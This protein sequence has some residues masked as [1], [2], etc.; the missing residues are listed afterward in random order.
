MYIG[1]HISIW[2]DRRNN[3]RLLSLLMSPACHCKGWDGLAGKAAGLY[4]TSPLFSVEKCNICVN[5]DMFITQW[6]H[7]CFNIS[8]IPTDI[9]SDR[10]SNLHTKQHAT[11]HQNMHTHDDVIK[12]KHFPRYWPFLRWIHRSPVNSQHKG[13]W[14]GA[15]MFSLIC[16]LNQRLGE[17]S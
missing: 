16:A 8:Y 1:P 14:R 9:P 12:W 7:V 10:V 5:M 15:L 17:Q 4:D 3:S 11:Y 2:T 6:Q 13:Q